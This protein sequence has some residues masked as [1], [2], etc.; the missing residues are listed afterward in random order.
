MLHDDE[1]VKL[2]AA[3]YDEDELDAPE[4]DD[5]DEEDEEEEEELS[6]PSSTH[7]EEA[8]MYAAP[9]SPVAPYEPPTEMSAEPAPMPVP[10]PRRQRRQ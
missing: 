7:A 9:P 4:P 3:G 6:G 10:P 2:Y 8:T 1:M 5:L